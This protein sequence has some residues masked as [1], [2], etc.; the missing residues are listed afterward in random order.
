MIRRAITG[1]KAG[2]S[3]ESLV[4]DVGNRL[5]S[6]QVTVDGVE[7]ALRDVLDQR[8]VGWLPSQTKRA[9]TS[10][11]DELGGVGVLGP[12]LRD[13]EIDEVMVNASGD[14]YIERFGRLEAT[15]VRFADSADVRHLIERVVSPLGLRI[16]ARSPWVDARLADGS[17]FHAV[18]PPI[19]LGGPVVTIRK[20]PEALWTIDD[21]VAS[22]S[23]ASAVAARLVEAVDA[24][25]NILVSGGGGTG[26][27][28]L[29]G[30]LARMVDEHERIVTIEDAAELRLGERHVVALETRPSNVEG[31]GE[32][33]LRDLVRCA[34]RMR[35]DRIVVGEV[36]G[37]EALDMIQALTSGHSG[38]MCTVHADAPEEALMRLEVM[39]LLAAPGLSAVAAR[40]QIGSAIDIVVH[41]ARNA[42]G[43]RCVSHVAEVKVGDDGPLL[44][45]FG[46]TP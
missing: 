27:T 40:R 20:F 1:G 38:S 34:M 26:K 30:V 35:A 41:L 3:R 22:G 8:H 5:P 18:V 33:T 15:T 19:A 29:L 24:R 45:Q 43:A 11:A 25:E 39:S 2:S 7:H 32:V 46:S 28:T 9:A 44:V 36:R 4:S 16:D 42:D 14:V 37:A 10:I 21:L 23:I 6:G 17:R 31:R 12:L 13:P